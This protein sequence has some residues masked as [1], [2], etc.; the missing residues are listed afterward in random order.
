MNQKIIDKIQSLH[1]KGFFYIFGSGV[2]NKIIG[3]MSSAIL[4]RIITKEEYGVF[5]YAWNIFSFILLLNGFGISYGILQI[6]SEKS[7]DYD[8]NYK[9][10]KWGQKFGISIDMIIAILIICIA[11]FIPLPIHNANYVLGLLCI[12][13]IFILIFEMQSSY[14]R[15]NKLSIEFSKISML[16]TFLIFLFSVIGAYIFKE[17]GLIYGRY[18][19]YFITIIYSAKFIKK[20]TDRVKE[21]DINTKLKNEIKN[22]SFTSMINSGLSQVLY[23]FDIFVIGLV[24]SSES[25]IASYKIA[26]MIPS[27]LS[28]IPLSLVTFIYPYF[29]QKY[30]DKKWCLSKY[31]ML[32]LY[33]GIFNLIISAVLFVFAPWIITILFGPEYLDAITSFRILTV[34][35]FFSGTFRVI[36]G[37]ILVTQ[38]ELKFNMFVA[39]FSGLVNIVVDFYFIKLWG[40]N[41]AAI[42]TLLVVILTS[43]L[44]VAYLIYRLKAKGDR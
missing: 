10:F 36:A 7:E 37:N 39:I 32:T 43:I 24:I 12:M 9:I 13:P 6:C 27:A 35:Y 33:F 16:N 31:N 18:I 14:L 42:A 38:K 26:T 23:L 22:I 34:S 3:F 40:A 21:L 5:T 41:G 28:F 2:L 29:A 11:L 44:N 20:G 19:A 25:T 1:K 4:V 15:A 8:L 17:F 30:K